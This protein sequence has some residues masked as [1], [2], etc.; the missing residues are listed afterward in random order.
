MDLDD[1]KSEW[2]QQANKI[3]NESVLSEQQIEALLQE[4]TSGTIGKLKRNLLIDFLMMLAVSVFVLAAAFW[5]YEKSTFYSR[6]LCAFV[7]IITVAYSMFTAYSW[8]RLRQVVEPKDT[9]K[10]VI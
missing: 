4:R 3:G 6:G 8:M 5:I 7:I 10:S 1:F 9:L 2:Q